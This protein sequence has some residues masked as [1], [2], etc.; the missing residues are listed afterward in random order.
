[1]KVD[2]FWDQPFKSADQLFNYVTTC[3]FFDPRPLTDEDGHV[4]RPKMDD[5]TAT[6][7]VIRNEAGKRRTKANERKRMKCRPIF[8]RWVNEFIPSLRAQ[9][10]CVSRDPV[11]S[12]TAGRV[13]IRDEAFARFL[14]EP[15]YKR[16]LREWRRQ[17][18]GLEMKKL[19]SEMVPDLPNPHYRGCLVSAMRKIILEDDRSYGIQPPTFIK[20]ADGL[21][22][23]DVVRRFIQERW[24]DVG[25]AAW[26]MQQQKAREAMAR[27]AVTMNSIL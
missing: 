3:R 14:V 10:E 5:P 11:G 4:E 2:G 25:E 13:A 26:T 9:I 15:E 18:Q 24:Q 20:D 1:M 12:I 8:R 21:Y 23:E 27:K 16:T 7:E 17:R 19:V 6:A 22:D